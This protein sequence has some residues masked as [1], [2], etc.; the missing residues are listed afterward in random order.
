ML[1]FAKRLSGSRTMGSELQDRF[2]GCMLGGL[3]GDCLGARFEGAYW[4]KVVDRDAVARLVSEMTNP[5]AKSAA[6]RSKALVVR[7]YTD[8][9]SMAFTLARSLLENDGYRERYLAKSFANDYKR[10]PGRGYGGSVI[11]VFMKLFEDS[12]RDCYKPAH[13]QFD[14]SGSYGNGAAMRV[15]PVALFCDDEQELERVAM[16]Q[17]MLTHANPDGVCGAV[18]QATAVHHCLHADRG[19]PFDVAAC[20]QRLRDAVERFPRQPAGAAAGSRTA[21]TTATASPITCGGSDSLATFLTQHSDYRATVDKYLKK[22]DTLSVLL[23]NPH[24]NQQEVMVE[25][26]N[27]IA[28]SEA[29]FAAIFSALRTLRMLNEPAQPSAEQPA[30]QKPVPEGAAGKEGKP[31]AGEFSAMTETIVHAI[32]LGGDTDT[33]ACMAGGIVGAYCGA[34]GISPSWK[35]VLESYATAVSLADKLCARRHKLHPQP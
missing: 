10:E 6:G 23:A 3:A 2:R 15:A 30:D 4:G 18:L 24:T 32:S 14:G 11:V 5:E 28:A 8:D 9:T 25:L 22:L 17:A 12:C 1:K 26:G 34:G 21:S 13:D 29:V 35:P 20:L 19:K 31:S 27:G 16:E 7:R 33:I